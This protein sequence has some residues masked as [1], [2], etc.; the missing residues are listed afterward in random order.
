MGA[1]YCDRDM[2][3]KQ[4][5]QNFAPKDPDMP[6]KVERGHEK[7]TRY[8]PEPTS[9]FGPRHQQRQASVGDCSRNVIFKD[10]VLSCF[11]GQAQHINEG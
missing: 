8:T 9:L 6:D 10:T 3:L 4:L 1:T 11:R 2:T 5:R 7:V